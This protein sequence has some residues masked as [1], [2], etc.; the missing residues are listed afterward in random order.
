LQSSLKPRAG[1]YSKTPIDMSPFPY[2]AGILLRGF[3]AYL[4]KGDAKL[5]RAQTPADLAILPASAVDGGDMGGA[6][7]DGVAVT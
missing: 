4:D 7:A 2:H 3:S 5:R 1:T 6:N